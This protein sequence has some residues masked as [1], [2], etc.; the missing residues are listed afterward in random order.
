M[1]Q[2]DVRRF[3]ERLG[4]TRKSK[5]VKSNFVETFA[6]LSLSLFPLHEALS[7][8]LPSPLAISADVY[9][10]RASRP[11]G[12]DQISHSLCDRSFSTNATSTRLCFIST[13]FNFHSESRG[14]PRD[15]IRHRK[16][17]DRA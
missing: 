5:I 11:R 3:Q 2:R 14:D 15:F 8:P 10:S 9:P 17:R 7:L 13:S 4:L 1:R 12:G 6:I 16:I